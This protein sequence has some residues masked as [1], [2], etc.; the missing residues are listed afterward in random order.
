MKPKNKTILK[1]EV[2]SMYVDYGS[3]T[4]TNKVHDKTTLITINKL[5]TDI[6]SKRFTKK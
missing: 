2:R 1:K 6:L 5:M 3:H 4:S